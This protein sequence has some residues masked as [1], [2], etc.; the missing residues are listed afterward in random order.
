MRA[1]RASLAERDA[2]FGTLYAD[3]RHKL[4]SA[5]DVVASMEEAGIDRTVVLGF[6]W[7]DAGMCRE[8]NDYLIDA[9]RRFPDELIGFASIQP[10]DARDAQEIER[11]LAAGLMGVGELGPDGQRFDIESKQ[12]LSAAAEVLTAA[13]KPLLTHASE[14]LGHAYAGKGQTFPW[15]VLKL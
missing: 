4:A 9:V 1:E 12:V 13:E 3:P 2:W 5:E 14:P 8:H 7:R 11:C 10:L 6:S 15:R